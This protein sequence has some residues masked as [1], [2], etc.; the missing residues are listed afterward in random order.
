VVF[1]D[2]ESVGTCQ[3]MYL[4][5]PLSSCRHLSGATAT[6]RRNS[7]KWL[8]PSRRCQPEPV[9]ER[10]TTETPTPCSRGDL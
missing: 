5:A 6:P 8:L 2:S 9:G 3:K 4:G 10:V 1:D 7:M